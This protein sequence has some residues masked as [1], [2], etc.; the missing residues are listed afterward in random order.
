MNQNSTLRQAAGQKSAY[1]EDCGEEPNVSMHGWQQNCKHQQT[2]LLKLEQHTNMK[3][4]VYHESE[5]GIC[6]PMASGKVE[7]QTWVVF[8]NVEHPCIFPRKNIIPIKMNPQVYLQS[9][10]NTRLQSI[11][12][13][14]LLSI[15]W[16]QHV[17]IYIALCALP[18][19][20]DESVS[21]KLMG[22]GIN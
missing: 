7:F 19:A 8:F 9:L 10:M 13:W 11:W 3:P 15:V 14:P 17:C 20:S 21:Y 4:C 12:A 16:T 1:T 2:P 18:S 6:Q 22:T 5:I